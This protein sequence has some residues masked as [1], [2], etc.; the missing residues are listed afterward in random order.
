MQFQTLNGETLTGE[1]WSPGPV[2]RSVWVLVD[3][4]P[5]AV[6]LPDA[7]RA[8]R[9]VDMNRRPKYGKPQPWT[10]EHGRRVL[11]AQWSRPEAKFAPPLAPKDWRLALAD[12]EQASA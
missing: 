12:D 8:A 6:R 7:G 3:G 2:A 4:S 10:R 11:A 5:Y 1:V 9:E